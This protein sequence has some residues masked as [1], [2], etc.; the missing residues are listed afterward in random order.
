M[1]VLPASVLIWSPEP[2]GGVTM[3]R[4]A[5][6]SRSG[7]VVSE[8]FVERLERVPMSHEVP[9]ITV[10]ILLRSTRSEDTIRKPLVWANVG[11]TWDLVFAADA[12]R[13]AGTVELGELGSV[14]I[15]LDALLRP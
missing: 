3:V 14:H 12:E 10:E 11:D 5:D 13:P 1:S 6:V 4:S 7:A 9:V 2:A 8:A 15:D